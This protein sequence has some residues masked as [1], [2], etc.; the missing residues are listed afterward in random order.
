[1]PTLGGKVQRQR[2]DWAVKL[3]RCVVHFLDVI[4]YEDLKIQNLVKNHHLAKSISDASWYQFTQWLDYFGKVWAKTVIAVAPHYTSQDCSNC[5]Y[6]VKKSLSTRTHQCP[7]CKTEICRDP[8]A[9]LNILKKGMNI[10]GIELNSG[11]T[12]VGSPDKRERAPREYPRAL[13]NGRLFGNA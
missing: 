12:P 11:A 13:G 2:K 1:M 9:A 10:L 4:V 6:R 3:A 5:S 8:N 7:Q